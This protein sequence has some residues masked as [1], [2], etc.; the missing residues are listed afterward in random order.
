VIDS[1]TALW[2]NVSV[3]AVEVVE[4]TEEADNQLLQESTL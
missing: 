2:W 3:E 4:A 1:T